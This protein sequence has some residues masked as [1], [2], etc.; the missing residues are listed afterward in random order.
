MAKVTIQ[1]TNLDFVSLSPR[2][3]TSLIVLHHVGYHYVVHKDGLI[4]RGRP[5]DMIGSHAQGSNAFSVG[6]CMVGDFNQEDPSAEQIEAVS[7]LVA[8]LGDKYGIVLDT[9]GVKPHREVCE[10]EC[11]G[12]NMTDEV[13]QNIR[14]K[15][16][17]YQQ[18]S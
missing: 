17:W 9:N 1:E 3:S 7:Q 15:A 18:N 11:P 16:I 4:E 13:I 6:I 8:V 10:T 12:A 5:V 14:G 2:S